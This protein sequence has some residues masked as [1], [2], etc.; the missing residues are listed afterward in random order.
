MVRRY[1]K[2][3]RVLQSGMR[4]DQTI[5]DGTGRVRNRTRN[6]SG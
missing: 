5:A 1:F 4:I 6:L 3:T 2:P